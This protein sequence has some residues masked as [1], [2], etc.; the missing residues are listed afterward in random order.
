[1]DAKE[2]RLSGEV[3]PRQLLIKPLQ[4]LREHAKLVIFRI[5]RTIPITKVIYV[6]IKKIVREDVGVPITTDEM[7]ARG[8]L[9]L[10]EQRQHVNRTLAGQS[11]MKPVRYGGEED[12]VVIPVDTIVEEL[13]PKRVPAEEI[14][15]NTRSVIPRVQFV[16]VLHADTSTLLSNQR[17]EEIILPVMVALANMKGGLNT[18]CG[19]KTIHDVRAAIFVIIHTLAGD[20]LVPLIGSATDNARLTQELR[21]NF[22]A[23]PS[24]VRDAPFSQIT[25][26]N[27]M[28]A[29]KALPALFAQANALS[30]ALPQGTTS[31]DIL[32]KG[33]ID[34]RDASFID[35][36]QTKVDQSFPD[37]LRQ[38]EWIN[39]PDKTWIGGY[40]PS[41]VI[42]DIRS[43]GANAVVVSDRLLDKQMEPMGYSDFRSKNFDNL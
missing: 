22:N 37:K 9:P 5:K 19:D 15:E 34:P 21:A 31:G 12:E 42:Y 16:F 3:R 8:H 4:Y 36:V 10:T 14:I 6:P 13:E 18:Y 38:K 25:Q 32:P 43:S 35:W 40:Q 26:A 29:H 17:S 1:M 39:E 7:G 24:V 20:R 28:A 27:A 23:D 30:L 33:V 11:P 41:L 2:I